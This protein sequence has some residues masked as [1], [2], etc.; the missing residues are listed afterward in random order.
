MRDDTSIISPS[1]AATQIMEPILLCFKI[2]SS[3][4]RASVCPCPVCAL[5]TRRVQGHY[6]HAL[7]RMPPAKCYIFTRMFVELEL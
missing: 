5:H 2:G 4:I 1:L 7:Y 6:S 3:R